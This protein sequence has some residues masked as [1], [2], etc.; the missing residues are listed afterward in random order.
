MATTTTDRILQLPVLQ[1]PIE[2]IESMESEIIAAC[3][4][5][6][7]G[8]TRIVRGQQKMVESSIKFWFQGL[9]AQTPR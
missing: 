2:T 5:S 1:L 3:E 4:Q 6:F 8:W 9:S 7:D